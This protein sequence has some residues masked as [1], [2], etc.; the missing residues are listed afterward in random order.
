MFAIIPLRDC[1]HLDR[2]ENLPSGGIDVNS[3][4][5]QCNTAIENWICLHCYTVHCAR[6][7]NQHALSHYEEVEHQITLSFTDLSVWCY[8][9]EAY[10]DNPVSINSNKREIF[11][12]FFVNLQRLYA[13]RNAAH[14]SKFNEELPWTYDDPPNQ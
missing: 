9:C 8:G 12:K 11:F 2:I 4:C 14:L 1:P 10:I 5:V 3:P 7:I 13:A 6:N